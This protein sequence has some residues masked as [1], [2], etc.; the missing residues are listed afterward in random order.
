MQTITSIHNPRVK[1]AIKLH[2]SRGR[3]QQ[4]RIIVFGQREIQRAVLSGV[5]PDEL[6]VLDSASD[7]ELANWLKARVA[8]FDDVAH[9]V[10]QTLFE[11]LA[12]GNR[13]DGVVMTA[14]RPPQ[15]VEEFEASLSAHSCPLILVADNIEK[16][17]N[18]GAMLRT[19]DGAGASGVVITG[20]GTDW[21]H[22][23]TIRASLGTAF[24]LPGVSLVES[25][26]AQWLT[27]Q[28]FQI[29]VAALQTNDSFYACD[30]TG[31]TAIVVGNEAT[32]VSAEWRSAA[33][34]VALPMLGIADSLNVSAT[35]AA[36]LYEANRQ[37]AVR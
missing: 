18:L 2:Q 14:A 29:I 35:T 12:F 32:G 23:N 36:M 22:P 34:A 19:A 10:P 30:L 31:P 26:A 25:E 15:R 13:L 8:G 5:T 17:G 16:P 27:R 21:F 4:G 37:R 1:S 24:S 9:S 20:G 28:K 33:R 11:K 3:K 7:S 6:F